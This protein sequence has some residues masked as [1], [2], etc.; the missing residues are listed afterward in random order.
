MFEH[1]AVGVIGTLKYS[2]ELVE[3]GSLVLIL[4]PTMDK[5]GYICRVDEYTPNTP[6]YIF[7]D[8]V[9]ILGDL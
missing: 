1:T 8:E 5:E 2:L 3:C 6:I 9:E 4:Y 7:K